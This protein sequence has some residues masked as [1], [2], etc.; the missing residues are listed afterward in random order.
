[1]TLHFKSQCTKQDKFH[2]EESIPLEETAIHCTIFLRDIRVIRAFPPFP[3]PPSL[4]L[5][6]CFSFPLILSFPPPL[7]FSFSH[8][9]HFIVHSFRIERNPTF[10]SRV[11]SSGY[12]PCNN[13]RRMEHLMAYL[14][15]DDNPWIKWTL[16]NEM[17]PCS[18]TVSSPSPEPPLSRLL[19]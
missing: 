19:D 15:I 3:P 10:V 18:C 16:P 4:S 9:S 17:T 12:G 7:V 13:A 11:K 5:S 2:R 1:M 14:L 8:Q 6:L